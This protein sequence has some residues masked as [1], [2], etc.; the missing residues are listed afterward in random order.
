LDSW[1]EDRHPDF[2]DAKTMLRA[3][4]TT[5]ITIR[6]GK[7]KISGDSTFICPWVFCGVCDKG[8]LSKEPQ[9]R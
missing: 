7:M 9:L 3:V 8:R 2:E 5:Q 4:Y 1:A 6:I